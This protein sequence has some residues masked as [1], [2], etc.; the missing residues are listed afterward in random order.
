[1]S[2]GSGGE[3]PKSELAGERSFAS[4]LRR[5]LPFIIL[6]AILALHSLR[7][8][9]VYIASDDLRWVT[10]TVADAR[11]PWHAFGEAPFSSY[12]RPVPHLAWLV[13]YY[14]W[15]FNFA[16][17][18]FMFILMWL[19]GAWLVYVVGCRFGGRTT[20]I[21]AAA[22]VG[23]NN[24]YLLISSWKSWY[25]TMTEFTA[26]LAWVYCFTKWLEFRQR[27]HLA[28]SIVLAVVAL[29]SRELAPLIISATVFIAVLL[30]MFGLS[31]STLWSGK[32]ARPGK[33]RAVGYLLIWALL[34]A[35]VLMAL[36]SYRGAAK[37]IFF[38][39][40]VSPAVAAAGEAK[41]VSA[42]YFFP[43]F[44]AHTRSIFLFGVTPYLLLFTVL[45]SVMRKLRVLGWLV[46]KQIF[47]FLL[48]FL[49]GAV[50][51]IVSS[52]PKPENFG[53]DILPWHFLP[54][55]ALTILLM[56][57]V[58]V[59][60]AT[61]N[62][63]RILGA[64]FVLSYIPIMFLKHVSM[65]YHMLAFTALALYTGVALQWFIEDEIQPLWKQ[66]GK[67]PDWS[68]NSVAGV[69]LAGIFLTLCLAQA[70]M[71]RMNYHN[72]DTLLQQ[73]ARN[74]KMRKQ[75]V[76][77]A[78]K[79]VLDHA[80]PHKRVWVSGE[81]GREYGDIACLIL[82]KKHGFKVERLDE[83]DPLLVGLREFESPLRVYSDVIQYDDKLFKQ[84]NMLVDGGFEAQNSRPTLSANA[85]T[86]KWALITRANKPGL[87]RRKA[88][89][90]PFDLDPEQGYVFG[91]FMKCQAERAENV[92][93]ALRRGGQNAYVRKTP[94]VNRKNP[95]WQLLSEC[96]APAAVS[97]TELKFRIIEFDLLENGTLLLD[98]IFLCPVKPLIAAARAR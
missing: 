87:R 29:L 15:G 59:S 65:A 88:E 60:L 52:A 24:I 11:Q 71:L 79:G 54:L 58:L 74:G 19:A 68:R 50:A 2:S 4:V 27:R 1:M 93:I 42:S 56:L 53:A 64:W 21:I 39:D 47:P 95:E 16:G 8:T 61:S 43:R 92:R 67:K 66:A 85:R 10:R 36:P 75:I 62:R 32:S 13:N 20:G 98:D 83:L 78:V 84:Y 55:P 44:S 14:I 26:L 9:G 28:G 49:A 6:L 86:G 63:T 22:L 31:D 23:L 5:H 41:Q 94:S 45:F 81:P 35:V 91:G 25:T 17:H 40:P 80:E 82:Q 30:P 69:L 96:A 12:F 48:L 89:I 70:A 38:P 3:Q 73:R 34:T 90:G 18:Q 77:D 57:F 97:C 51:G 33:R 76:A 46:G 72:V 7:T 37:A